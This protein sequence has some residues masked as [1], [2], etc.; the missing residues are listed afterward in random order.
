MQLKHLTILFFFSLS[1][2]I[3]AQQKKSSST[4]KE[5]SLTAGKESKKTTSF[6]KSKNKITEDTLVFGTC[7]YVIKTKVSEDS[8]RGEVCKY[9]ISFAPMCPFPN[10]CRS[11]NT[12]YIT[13]TYKENGKWKKNITVPFDC[14]ITFYKRGYIG[15]SKTNPKKEYK[16][17][18]IGGYKSGMD[19]EMW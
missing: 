11:N 8:C 10:E 15:N 9:Y 16:I 2:S 18:N 12:L 17:K 13:L 7:K 14:S 3:N 6:A 19:F 4:K 1:C 5:N